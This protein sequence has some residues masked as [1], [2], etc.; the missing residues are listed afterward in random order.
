MGGAMLLQDQAMASYEGFGK[1]TTDKL[2]KEVWIGSN[3]DTPFLYV[4][5]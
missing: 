4:C 1:Q 3:G 5:F 2:D